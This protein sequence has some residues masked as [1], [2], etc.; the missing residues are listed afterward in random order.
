MDFVYGWER[1]AH[2][3][4]RPYHWSDH[5]WEYL[6]L[7]KVAEA[8]LIPTRKFDSTT[9]GELLD[10]WWERHAEH[11]KYKFSYLMPRLD[12]FRKLKARNL[13]PEM[14]QDFLDELLKTRSPASV[15]HYRTIINSAFNFAM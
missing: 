11:R 9:V 4:K 2:S 13:T 14:V 6:R 10:F 8:K 12:K 3:R 15:N 7:A 5:N 1:Q